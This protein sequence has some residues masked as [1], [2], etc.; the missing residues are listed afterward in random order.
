M[1]QL[2]AHGWLGRQDDAR[3]AALV[4]RGDAAAFEALY[5]RHHASLLAFCRHMLGNRE[6]G[7]EA[8]QQ[9]FLRAHQ[10]LSNGRPPQ[11]LRPW[12]FA[13]ARNRCRTMLAGRR[14]AP[15]PS[16]LP[17]TG[18]DDLAEQVRRRAELRELIADLGRLPEEQRAALVLAELGDL[19]HGDIGSVL[20]CAP[21]KVKALVFQAREALVADRDARCIPCTQIR[22]LLETATGGVLRRASLRRHLKQC[23]PCDAYRLVVSGRRGGLGTLLPVAPTAGLKAAI[24]G[25]AGLWGG[26][27]ASAAVVAAGA[28]SGA[29]TAAVAGVTLKAVAAKV[30]VTAAIA[31]AGVSGG[32]AVAEDPAPVPASESVARVEPVKPTPRGAPR[33]WPASTTRVAGPAGTTLVRQPRAARTTTRHVVGRARRQARV[34]RRQARVARRLRRQTRVARR[35]TRV[36]RRLRAARRARRAEIRTASSVT[37]VAPSRPRARQP[38]PAGTAPALRPRRRP[39]A[40]PRPPVLPAPTAEP[41]PGAT[42]EPTPGATAESPLRPRRAR[43]EAWRVTPVGSPSGRARDAGLGRGRR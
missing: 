30:A 20:G 19:S 1:T 7:E 36:A 3:L 2:R 28:A 24:L 29:G 37:S 35:Q 32:L 10:A 14:D 23:A 11:T 13:I 21:Q 9:T 38:I 15:V 40:R 34:A 6:D 31:G 43:R 8:L 25:G 17:E 41:T 26:E 42:A 4:A 33:R 12:L 16:E 39:R 22:G 5:D 27:S 18:V